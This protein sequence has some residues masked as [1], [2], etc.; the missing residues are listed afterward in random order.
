VEPRR[1]VVRIVDVA[2]PAAARALPGLGPIA[3]Q[4]VIAADHR[5]VAEARSDDVLVLFVP[6]TFEVEPQYR[7]L[8]ADLARA[9][10]RNRVTRLV[11]AWC[12]PERERPRMSAPHRTAAGYDP[13]IGPSGWNASHL[14]TAD[15]WQRTVLHQ[16]GD[17]LAAAR[18]RD[19]LLRRLFGADSHRSIGGQHMGQVIDLFDRIDPIHVHAAIVEVGDPPR[20]FDVRS[21]VAAALARTDSGSH[22]AR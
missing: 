2:A 12:L 5:A 10:D 17:Q 14:F 11:V 9:A 15:A 7:Q 4:E 8:L 13:G 16:G 22:G 1:A 19:Q 20:W 18:E 6:A 21:V 3:E